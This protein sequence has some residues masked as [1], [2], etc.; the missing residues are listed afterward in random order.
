MLCAAGGLGWFVFPDRIAS[1]YEAVVGGSPQGDGGGGPPVVTV[2]ATRAEEAQWERVLNTVGTVYA[3]QGIEVTS[4]VTGI[5]S[6][7]RF[8]GGE[9]VRRGDILVTLDAS[10]EEAERATVEA[11]LLQAEREA[12]RS[13]ELLD[14]N[15]IAQ[16]A[17]EDVVLEA[18]ALR[19]ELET[20]QAI[21]DL[22]TI[23]APFE[24]TLGIRY[25]D[26]G[27]YVEPGDEIFSLQNLSEVNVVFS[28][29]EEDIGRIAV[30]QPVTG[31]FAAYPGRTFSGEVTTLNPIVSETSRGLTV[32]ARFD[33][34]SG[35]LLPGMFASLDVTLG[36]DRK[37]LLIPQRAV[38]YN[39]YG[40][41][42]FVTS[43]DRAQDGGGAGTE[44][45][46]LGSARASTMDAADIQLI[47]TRT[48]IELGERRGNLIE[49][50]EGLEPGTRVITGGQI[51]LSDGSP[52]QI[53]ETDP[54][55]AT[56]TE[57]GMPGVDR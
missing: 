29:P 26:L 35:D 5:I 21:I 24:G 57:T 23:R 56:D 9:E 53:S 41:S 6:S 18:A 45:Q 11:R 34:A 46:P 8:A 4:Q 27:E 48:F 54:L 47:A 32:Q 20:A 7:I 12:A 52:I 42:V 31:R 16:E 40:A 37:V 30:G 14:R 49:V 25:V 33:N 43:E 39:A 1:I 2:T 10:R 55:A 15:V 3:A 13:S 19:A 51:N 22:K 50:T 17:A 44:D 38:S 28:V 36:D